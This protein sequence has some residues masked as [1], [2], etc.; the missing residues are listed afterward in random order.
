M[1]LR[2]HEDEE[3][4]TVFVVREGKAV[5]TP[6]KT[7]ESSD[8][9]IQVTDG[10]EPG[11]IVITGPYKVLSKLKD[12]KS[13]TVRK[14]KKDGEDSEEEPAVRVRRVRIGG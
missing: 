3:K 11:D 7:G 2:E 4:E 5:L 12:G 13:V 14:D 10:L 8:T 9:E 1:G 6:I